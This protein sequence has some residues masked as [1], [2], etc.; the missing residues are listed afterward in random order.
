MRLTRDADQDRRA[1]FPA[2]EVDLLL[3]TEQGAARVGMEPQDYFPQLVSEMVKSDLK[4]I[5]QESQV[6]EV[7]NG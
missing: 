7:S 3:A 2:T 1:L 6:R 4:V 5:A